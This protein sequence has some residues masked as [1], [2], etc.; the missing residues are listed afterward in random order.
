MPAANKKDEEHDYRSLLSHTREQQYDQ[1]QQQVKVLLNAQRPHMRERALCRVVHPQICR[2]G[3]Q[4][5][6][7]GHAICLAPLRHEQVQRDHY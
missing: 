1:R 4:L 3:Q 7:S 5:P 6:R 2:E